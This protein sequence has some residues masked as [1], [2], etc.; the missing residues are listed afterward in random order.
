MK[1]ERIVEILILL[2]IAAVAAFVSYK[3]YYNT[4]VKPNL[5]TIRFH[6]IDSIIKGSPVRLMG[7]IVGHVRNLTRENDIILCEIVVTKPNT[8][9]PDGAVARVE[10][11]GLGGSKSIEISPPKTNDS[12]IKGIVATDALRISDFMDVFQDVREV[13]VCIKE[14]VNGLSPKATV[15]TLR[16]ISEAPDFTVDANKTL[17]KMTAKQK[18]NTVKIRHFGKFQKEME[19]IIDKMSPK[20]NRAK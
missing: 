13:L 1:K 5:Y 6:D 15:D 14:F 16:A 17:D 3:I 19:K 10:Y 7:I 8:K 18:E 20:N 9:I 2:T 4:Y 11:N 12:D